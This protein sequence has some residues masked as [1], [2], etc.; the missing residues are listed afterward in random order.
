MK[1]PDF[2]GPE[3]LDFRGLFSSASPS[4]IEAAC[5]YEYMRESQTLRDSVSG[6]RKS[7]QRLPSPFL[8]N[9]SLPRLGFLIVKLQRAGFPKPWKQLP[10]RFQALLV[11]L[12][13]T[14]GKRSGNAKLYPQV[15]IE[16]G[17]PE[18]DYSENSWRMGQLQP[19]ELSLFKGWEHSG[20]KC[21]FGFIRIDTGYNE[22]EA[23]QA[24]RM[25]FRKHWPKTKSG[26]SAKWRE[27]IN[28]LV[29]MRIWKHERNQWK[30]LKLVAKFCGY[31]GCIKEAAAY[32]KR[33][34]AGHANEPMSEAAKVEMSKA[35]GAARTFFQG[36]FPREE[37]LSY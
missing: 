18:F 27:R 31:E 34:G 26:G 13:A 30:R 11:S 37:P 12:L 6:E 1:N 22:T 32:K 3:N 17:Q 15:I 23:S 20:R 24:F 33:C 2:D 35:R 25:A 7:D 29:V 4:E 10:K 36:L 9:F 5:L 28:Q 8:P 19:F 16:Q 21:F 14:G